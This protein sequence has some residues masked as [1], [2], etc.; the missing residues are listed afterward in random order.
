MDL[1][2]LLTVVGAGLTTFLVV[3][4]VVIE[5]LA[6]EFSAII[7]LP[8]GLIA[9]LAVLVILWG[10]LDEVSVGVRRAVSAYAVFGLA[11]LGFFALRYVNIGRDVL[12]VDRIIVL[13]IGLAVVVYG[14]HVVADRH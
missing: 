2:K 10:Q 14:L 8:V 13:G 3:A 5:V 11:V 6:M 12:T 1:R 7:G 9:G 4:V